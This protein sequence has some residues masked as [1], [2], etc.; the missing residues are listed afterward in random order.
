MTTPVWRSIASASNSTAIERSGSSRDHA[1]QEERPGRRCRS[2]PHRKPRRPKSA[3]PT[4]RSPALKNSA[5]IPAHQQSYFGHLLAFY[6]EERGSISFVDIKPLFAPLCVCSSNISP[7]C[8][9]NFDNFFSEE[10][11]IAQ[12]LQVSSQMTLSFSRI[13]VFSFGCFDFLLRLTLGFRNAHACELPQER[14]TGHKIA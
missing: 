12:S 2:G 5:A 13:S 3:Q 9:T 6:C 7:K 11:S 4:N 8:P 10:L 14:R 1:D